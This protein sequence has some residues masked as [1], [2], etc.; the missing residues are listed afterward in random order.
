MDVGSFRIPVETEQTG[1]FVGPA[2]HPEQSSAA[3]GAQ[4]PFFENGYLDSGAF[5]E[6]TD[7]MDESG[8]P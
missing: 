3:L 2:P 7:T 6:G 5:D 8:G 4:I 1:C